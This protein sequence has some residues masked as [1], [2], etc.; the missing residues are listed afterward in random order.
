MRSKPLPERPPPAR[1]RSTAPSPALAAEPTPDLSMRTLLLRSW[2]GRLFL[3]GAA[4]KVIV[5]VIR[6]VGEVPAFIRVLS[7]AAT[8]TLI[9]SVGYFVW[10]LIVLM[11]R[12]L[13]WRVRRKL[14]LSYIFIGVVPALLIVGFF[15]LGAVVM[16]MNISAYLF[17]DGY[18]DIVT[19]AR[20]AAEG[21]ASEIARMP[22]R[23]PDSVTRIQRN[24]SRLNRG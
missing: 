24:A 7:T 3:I 2:A 23:T 16:S 1:R 4:L 20:V 18:D 10:R 22:E 5:T 6:A 8:I 21:A 12:R 17:R 9:I 15:L 14:I 11:K 13:L 19:F